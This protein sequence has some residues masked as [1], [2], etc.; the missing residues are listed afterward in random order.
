MRLSWRRSPHLLLPV[1][2]GDDEPEDG[3]DGEEDGRRDEDG[4][5][6]GERQTQR[7]PADR[8]HNATSPSPLLHCLTPLLHCLTPNPHAPSLP[9]SPPTRPLL[10]FSSEYWLKIYLNKNN[11]FKLKIRFFLL[12]KFM[13]FFNPASTLPLL[14]SLLRFITSPSPPPHPFYRP[15]SHPSFIFP[16]KTFGSSASDAAV[17]NVKYN[18]NPRINLHWLHAVC[19]KKK[20]VYCK[21]TRAY[22]LALSAAVSQ[23]AT[24]NYIH[25][26]Y[27]ILFLVFTSICD[28]S[29]TRFSPGRFVWWGRDH[30]ITRFSPGR[31]VWWWRDRNELRIRNN[32]LPHSI[33]WRVLFDRKNYQSTCIIFSDTQAYSIPYYVTTG[34]LGYGIYRLTVSSPQLSLITYS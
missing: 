3:A 2:D 11:R 10:K 19:D 12:T 25:T 17:V 22:L 9:R 27:S 4:V 26:L 33:T 6:R 24:N 15:L 18:S 29:L 1:E 7:P 20:T 31:F 23:A 8:T 14:N 13:I 28:T 34:C 16:Q 30:I 21:S 5:A 32:L